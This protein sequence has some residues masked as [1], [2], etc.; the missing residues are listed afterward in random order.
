MNH[1]DPARTDD[2]PDARR[3]A[4]RLEEFRDHL[5]GRLD[6]A[7]ASRLRARL[8]ADRALAA[9]FEAYAAVHAFTA[10]AASAPACG[11][12]FE[13]VDA[14]RRTGGLRRMRP[15]LAAAAAVLVVAAGA[16]AWRR[17]H[18]EPVEVTLHAISLAAATQTP[19]QPS[20]QTAS[21]SASATAAEI[22]ALLATYRPVEDGTVRWIAS[23]DEG[24]AIARA[25]GRP[26]FLWIYH[27]S[28]PV[29][30]EWDNGAFRDAEVQAK[31][32]EFVPVRVDVMQATSEIKELLQET[33]DWPYLGTMRAD[34]S[35]LLEFSGMQSI[36]EVRGHLDAALATTG[37]RGPGLSWPEINAVAGE[38]VK[39]RA[40]FAAGDVATAYR[41]LDAAARR[42][43]EGVLGGAAKPALAEISRDA[44]KA[45]LDARDRAASDDPD[46]RRAGA[47]SLSEA[48]ERF[49]GTP[50]GTDLAE[51]EQ[52]LRATGRFPVLLEITKR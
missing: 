24:R 4:A 45:L 31:A 43:P 29:C 19:T 23:L 47:R 52:G 22:P 28:C 25:A 39:G 18:P 12:S 48:A 13:R 35:Q 34:G 5:D 1:M 41:E 10:P 36:A 14:A 11:V 21:A 2:S 37:G 38:I 50:Y 15:W 40:A 8:V 26:I 17:S 46:V 9:D 49:R 16:A 42:D 32:G 30:V 33:R 27:P 3:D 51:V 6:Q 7:A 44:A 20:T